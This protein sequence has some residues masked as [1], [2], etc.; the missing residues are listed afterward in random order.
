MKK[1]FIGID[2]SKLTLDASLVARG[3]DTLLGFG[4]FEN[5]AQGFE[6][7][8]AWILEKTHCP[9]ESW[10]ICGEHTG[11]YSYGLSQYAHDKGIDLWLESALQIKLSKG[12]SREKTDP[13]DATAIARYAMRFEDRAKLY[14]PSSGILEEIK[15]LLS[16]RDRL[17]KVKGS[18]SKAAKE[19]TRIKHS[20][21]S[22]RFIDEDSQLLVTEMEEQVRAVEGRMNELLLQDAGLTE[23][24]QLLTSSKGIGAINAL[25]IIVLTGNFTLFDNARKFGCYCGV[26][27]FE[28]SSGTSVR[29][30]ARVSHLA[31]K[32]MKVLLTQ[33][34]RTAVTYNPVLKAYFE[35]KK[36]EGK[37]GL[38]IINNVRNKL[39]HTMFALV[40]KHQQYDINFKHPLAEAA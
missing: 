31:N 29:G 11:L 25:M 2:F 36:K 8:I 18:L 30:K 6:A 14:R 1:F 12:M 19:L 24:Y 26:V 9:S 7:L 15:D 28:H 32:Q 3:S 13:V 17:I 40:K 27:P 33:A 34:A 16:Y 21:A 5:S 23:T 20:S 4:K 22:A 38:L 39:I 10:L 35:R 37:H